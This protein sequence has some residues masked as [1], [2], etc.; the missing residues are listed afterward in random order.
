MIFKFLN[1]P[2]TF[3]RSRNDRFCFTAKRRKTCDHYN[4]TKRDF[5]HSCQN[6]LSPVY[7]LGNERLGRYWRHLFDSR[8]HTTF[9]LWGRFI[10]WTISCEQV[11]N[12]HSC[13]AF[14]VTL[15]EVTH[16]SFQVTSTQQAANVF[17]L[18]RE[19]ATFL[20]VVKIRPPSLPPRWL[21]YI[22]HLRKLLNFT[23]QDCH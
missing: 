22:N 21:S 9:S 1:R 14:W 17:F 15:I 18:R 11:R 2:L 8:K 12:I 10:S 13:T 3:V 16:K 4:A 19:Q 20:G 5:F 6:V 7:K 23:A